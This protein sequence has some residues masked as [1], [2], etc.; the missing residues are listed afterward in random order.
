MRFVG[1]DAYEADGGIVR[2]DLFDDDQG[3]FLSD[4]ELLNRLASEKLETLAA[5]VREEGC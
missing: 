1:V 3:R 5:S 4:P 2:R